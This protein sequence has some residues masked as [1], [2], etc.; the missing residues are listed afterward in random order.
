[1]FVDHVQ[2]RVAA[3]KGGS[4]MVAFSRQPFENRGGPCGG[5]GGA[6]GNV[7]V[8]ANHNI[9]DLSHIANS[10][11]ERRAENG[12]GGG[13]DNRQGK[14]AADLVLD[15]PIGTSVHEIVQ[16]APGRFLCLLAE[17][18]QQHTLA[19]GG[20]GGRGNRSFLSSAN[21]SPKLAEA[22]VE[23]AAMDISLT[24]SIPSDGCIL[25][26]PNSGKSA[27]LSRL[28]GASPAVSEHPYATTF[29]VKGSMITERHNFTLVELPSLD[30][31]AH[32]GKG[33]GNRF[34]Q[35]LGGTGT[36]IFLL[37]LAAEDPAAQLRLLREQVRHYSPVLAGRPNIVV[38]S[39]ADAL[40]A[41][42][43]QQALDALEEPPH[44]VSAA[45]GAGVPELAAAL[46][47][48]FLLARGGAPAEASAED[49]LPVLRPRPADAPVRVISEGAGRY[50]IVHPLAV[51][52]AAGSNL[53]DP[54]ALIQYRAKMEELRLTAAMEAAGVAPGSDVAVAQWNFVWG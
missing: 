1:M 47:E 18:G 5:A 37:D 21:Q 34:L 31:H 42:E 22:G 8:A 7:V 10:R 16:D 48:A 33:L 3:G 41:A 43:L 38:A 54:E 35:H 25:G 15:L 44:A 14:S 29:P 46:E 50:R 32:E 45:S 51:R 17:H 26:T 49:D 27:L 53:N 52:L 20:R 30:T 39:K 40:S 11:R 2:L 13:K 19:H 36:V 28:T 9:N 23:G 6:G 12:A 24:L 4:G